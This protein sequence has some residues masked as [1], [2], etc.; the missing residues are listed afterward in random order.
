MS[1]ARSFADKDATIWE[2]STT[3]NTGASPILELKNV[4]NRLTSRKEFTRTLV[5]FGLSSLTG[6][7]IS[8]VY[9]D[10]RTDSTVTAYLY[11]YNARHGDT[12]AKSFSLLALY[13][14]AK[15]SFPPDTNAPIFIINF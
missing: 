10:P 6:N 3:A 4:F 5:R 12:Q 7:I 8:G 13:P 1:Y 14:A 15:P 2:A 9:P 11:I